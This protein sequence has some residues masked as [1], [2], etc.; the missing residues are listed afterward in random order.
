M[1]SFKADSPYTNR[2]WLMQAPFIVLVSAA[3]GLLGAAFNVMRKKLWPI[4]ASRK[5]TVLRLAEAAGVALASVLLT[6]AVSLTVGRCV[7]LVVVG[8]VGCGVL[9]W[10]GLCCPNLT[11]STVKRGQGCP[12]V[13]GVSQH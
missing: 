6:A 3:G 2:Q 10:A 4:R 8:H 13:I 9:G 5:R 12:V 7:P 1:L 11:P